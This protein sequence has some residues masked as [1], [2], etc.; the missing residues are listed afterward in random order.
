MWSVEG[1]KMKGK[2]I[3]AGQI[4][5]QCIANDVAARARGR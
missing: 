2:F 4:M 3:K 1:V 5:E